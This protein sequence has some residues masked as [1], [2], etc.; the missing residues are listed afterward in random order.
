M[1][2]AVARNWW[3]LALR[4]LAAVLFGL[5]TF[6]WPDITLFV[7]VLMFGAYAFVDGIFALVAAFSDRAGKQR[8]W[9]LLLEGLAGIAAGIL[10][11]IWPGMTAFVLLYLIAAWAIVTGIFEV[12]AAIRL[13]REIE[14]EWL[15]ALGGIASIIFGILMVIWPGAGALTVVWLIGS[16]AFVFGLLMI[17]LAFRL[18]SWSKHREDYLPST[19]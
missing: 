9:V 17:F 8:W 6:V 7:L 13:R 5:A 11:F 3:T 1:I 15:L 18:R 19:S 2:Q 10:T 16:Y 4:G 12:I 14:G